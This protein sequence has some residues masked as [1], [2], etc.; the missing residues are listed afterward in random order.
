[1]GDGGED[2]WNKAKKKRGQI[3]HYNDKN[4]DDRK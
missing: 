1:M 2:D 4:V 3:S